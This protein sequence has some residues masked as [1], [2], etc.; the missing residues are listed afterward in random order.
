M[1]LTSPAWQAW[2]GRVHHDLVKRMVWPA[3]DRRDMA[4]AA[5]PRPGELVARLIDE[6][7]TAV[8]APA[9]WALLR[10]ELPAPAPAEALAAFATAVASAEQ[11]A[12]AGDVDGVLALDEAFRALSRAVTGGR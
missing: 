12:H 2:L 11:A 1:S 6:E 3:R 8:S 9:L 7:G 10:G 5:P 4:G